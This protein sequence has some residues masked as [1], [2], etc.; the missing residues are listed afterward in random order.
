MHRP[1]LSPEFTGIPS[2]TTNQNVRYYFARL[3]TP[4]E[5]TKSTSQQPFE[6][7]RRTEGKWVLCGDVSSFMYKLLK[8][9]PDAPLP[10]RLTAFNSPAGFSYGVLTHQIGRNQHRFVLGL[11]D[12]LVRAFLESIATSGM[13]MF[14]LGNDDEEDAL[15]FENP[16]L[17]SSFL[18]LLAMSP[19]ANL[20]IQ[21]AALSEL[22]LVQAAMGDPSQVPSLFEGYAVQHVSVS[23]LM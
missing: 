15:L 2:G 11:T 7:R 17:P 1:T 8:E 9:V 18:P 12:P 21:R 23:L 13:L 16:L 4:S 5:V 6:V 10:T 14:M 19:E 20:E 22:P 3:M